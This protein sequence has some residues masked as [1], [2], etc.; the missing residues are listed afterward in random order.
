MDR[1]NLLRGAA[2]TLAASAG[3]CAGTGRA[4]AGPR[5]GYFPNVLLRTQED[6]PVRFY[7]DL[8]AGKFVVINFMYASCG[9]ICPG[10]TANLVEV[11]R[12]LGGRVGRDI[13][14]YSLTLEPDA[15]TPAV[16]KAY[17]DV[18]DV[19]PG[20]SFLTGKRDD[21]ELLRRRLGFVDPDP[22][23]DADREQHIGMVRYGIE[24]LDRWAG[25]PALTAP[26]QLVR[27]ILR[28]EQANAA[29]AAG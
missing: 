5:A 27:S 29:P 16:L 6:R 23:L 15:D 3:L 24:R 18:F 14:M 21:I 4:A 1:R 26:E 19:G 9:D 8:I 25:C 28:M 2:A 17:A 10:M 22:L 13:F 7:D 12:L 20:W 11:Q